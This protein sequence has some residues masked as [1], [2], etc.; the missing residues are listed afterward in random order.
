[1]TKR[2]FRSILLVAVI[3]LLAALLIVT[4]VLYNYFSQVQMEQLRTET[5]LAS[6]GVFL[7][8]QSYLDGLSLSDTRITWVASDG[9]VLYDSVVDEATMENHLGRDEIREALESGYGES[10]RYSDTLTA[11][12]L[13]AAQKLP[14][15]SVLRLATASRTVLRLLLNVLLPSVV[16]LSVA[17]LLA[18]L[19]ASRVSHKIVKPLNEIDLDN[20]SKVG[21]Y[22]ELMPLLRRISS[23][24]YHLEKQQNELSRKQEEFNT[25]TDGMSEGI[26]LIGERRLILSINRAAKNLLQVKEDCVGLDISHLDPALGLE[27]LLEATEKVGHAEKIIEKNN[28]E[29]R[30]SVSPVSQN[31]RTVGFALLFF[32]ITEKEKN[33]KM[34]REFTANVSHE[35]KTPLHSISGCAELLLNGI[36]KPEDIPTFAGQI[37]AEAGRM[38]DLIDDIIRLSRLDEGQTDDRFAAVDLFLIAEEVRK[39]LAAQA[40]KANVTLSLS[41][42]K[43]MLDGIPQMLYAILHNLCE[44]AIKYN[45]PGGR[46]ELSVK[47]ER[48][49]VIL[50]VK[51]TGIGIPPEHHE[52]IFERFYRVDKSH[53]KEVGGTGL[54]LSIVKHAA[55]LH[56]ADI[57][58]ESTP[59]IG[60]SITVSFPCRD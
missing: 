3:V 45:R 4:G 41:G 54:G 14:D 16:L 60:T 32:D 58:L 5:K 38:I 27:M 43:A 47:K 29:Y 51:D 13:Y 40:E 26:L 30:L 21:E 48:G 34:R 9:T 17:I 15:G 50:L 10:L 57:S 42:E 31:G 46:V 52:R 44:N 24:K 2:I 36:V 1:M 7:E 56:N 35:L 18:S 20:P 6:Q 12:Q 53:S 55:S 37:H 19:L 25:A 23:Q 49:A 28:L 8:G 33:E 39:E 11:R 22:E 59:G